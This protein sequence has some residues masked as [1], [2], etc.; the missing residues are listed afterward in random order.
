[1]RE[2]LRILAFYAIFWIVLQIVIRGVFLLYNHDLTEQLSGSEVLQVFLHGLKMDISMSGYF[3]MLTSLILTLSVFYPTRWLYLILHSLSILGIVLSGVVLM[4]DMELYRHWGF[5][6]DTTPLFYLLGAESE[7]MG[8]VVISVV[9]NLLLIAAALI[10]VGIF[11]YSWW[12]MPKLKTLTVSTKRR[13]F[14]FFVI[15]ILMIIPIR[16]SFS[17]A[18]M[19]TGFVYFHKTKMYANHAAINVVWNFLYSLSKKANI[20]Y[21]ENFFDATQSEKYFNE[22]HPK[23]DSTVHVFKTERPNIILLILESFTADVVEP[24]GGVKGLTPNFTALCKEGILFENFY[25]SGDRTDKGVMSI[26][27]G[28]PAQPQTN[29]I[30]Y[31][32]KTQKLPYLVKEMNDLGYNTSFIHGGDLD[33]ANFRSYFTNSGFDHMTGIADFPENDLESKWGLHDEIVF[34]QAM[35]ELDT[36]KTPF[37]NVILT[38]SSHE[39]FDVPMEPF[40]KLTEDEESYFLNS[41]HY[42]DNCIG[43]FFDHAKKSSYWDNTVVILVADHGHRHPG[44]KELKDRRRFRIPLLMVGGAITKDSVVTK[45]GNHT[46]IANTL[47]AQLDKPNADFKFSKNLFSPESK[48][49]SF[50]FFNNGFGY[51]APD[52]YVVYDN[53][54]KQFVNREG[55]NEQDLHKTKAYQQILYSD[56]N[57]K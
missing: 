44:K 30:K 46:D 36:A 38:L 28:Y 9:I 37:F 23:D 33:F 35:K 31:P 49:F 16:G 5:R 18:P 42:V 47:L 50:Y 22:F 13:A 40:V 15:T 7:A 39:P 11:I 45:Y 19:N 25:S 26:L 54:A 4:I 56:Y 24:L 17:V 57:R 27:S 20:K 34:D 6:L 51:V 21:P 8:S 52:Q 48:S 12:L 32:A 43:K 29:I 53:N 10:A 2:R 41:I 55:V 3:L 14:T 1:M